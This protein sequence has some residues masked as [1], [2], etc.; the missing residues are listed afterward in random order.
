M[1]FAK[2]LEKT[3]PLIAINILITIIVHG[4]G[5][6]KSPRFVIT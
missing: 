5:V 6:E 3:L 4:T 2:N 1:L